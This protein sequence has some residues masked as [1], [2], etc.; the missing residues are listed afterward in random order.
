MR[1]L[2]KLES[3]AYRKALADGEFN[4]VYSVFEYDDCVEVTGIIDGIV[5][6]LYYD[7]DELIV[8]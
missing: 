2:N 6:C 3:V 8:L 1:R 4:R 7:F 5:M